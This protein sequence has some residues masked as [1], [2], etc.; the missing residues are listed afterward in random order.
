[1]VIMLFLGPAPGVAPAGWQHHV[2]VDVSI[3]PVAQ[4]VMQQGE[5]VVG[6]LPRV[7]P[8]AAL[9]LGLKEPKLWPALMRPLHRPFACPLIPYPR[10][11]GPGTRIN[12]GG[13]RLSAP[14]SIVTVT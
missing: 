12:Q 10:H 4:V 6:V 13:V 5:H 1:M 14:S 3:H 7:A 9:A 8:I 11:K 2:P